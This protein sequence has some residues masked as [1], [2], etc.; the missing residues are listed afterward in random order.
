MDGEPNEGNYEQM[1]Q[2]DGDDS[3]KQEIIQ[4]KRHNIQ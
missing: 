4:I 1:L 2:H 3:S